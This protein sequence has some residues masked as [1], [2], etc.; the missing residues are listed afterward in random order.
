MSILDWFMNKPEPVLKEPSEEQCHVL[1]GYDLR[2]WDYLGCSEVFFT[3]DAEMQ[4]KY[5]ANI[6]FF[7]LKG[8]DNVRSYTILHHHGKMYDYEKHSWV[9]G[10]ADPWR[11]NELEWYIPINLKPSEYTKQRMMTEFNSRWDPNVSWWV[12]AEKT[13]YQ[14]PPKRKKKTETEVKENVVKVDFNAKNNED[15]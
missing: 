2:K 15:T 11:A 7:M 14:A 1:H 6:Y 9:S 5:T 4:S 3:Y 12:S 8:N 10:N 13:N